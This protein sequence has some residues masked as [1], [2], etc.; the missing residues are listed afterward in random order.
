MDA[1]AEGRPKSVV[2]SE[3][4]VAVPKLIPQDRHV[5]YRE[6]EATMG[7]SMTSIHKIVHERLYVKTIR[8]RCIFNLTI[9]P[10]RIVFI[11]V[12]HKI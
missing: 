7:I 10:K 6:I 4:I 11:G 5:I 1:Y 9:A 12:R 2:E 3:N 8:A